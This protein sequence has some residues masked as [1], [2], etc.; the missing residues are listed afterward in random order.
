MV[1]AES[2]RAGM[3]RMRLSRRTGDAGL[4]GS[5][6]KDVWGGGTLIINRRGE[7]GGGESLVGIRLGE[8]SERNG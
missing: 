5:V 1:R 8:C 3:E 4:D 6:V 7:A 2:E